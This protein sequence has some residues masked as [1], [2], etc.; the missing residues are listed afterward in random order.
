MDVLHPV[1]CGID[2]H[3]DKLTVC[4]FS[5]P[6]NGKKDRKSISTFSTFPGDLVKLRSFLV[7][8]Q[9]SAVAMEATGIYWKPVYAAL[10]GSCEI[11]VSNAQ[12]IKNVPGRKTDVVDSQWIA[13]LCSL[14]LLA[15]S[16]VPDMPIRELQQLT[17]ERTHLA[18]ERATMVNRLHR[19]LDQQ[20][21]K[22]GSV[23]S[24]LQGTSAKDIL[25]LLA[26]GETDVSKMAECARTTL[27]KRKDELMQALAAPLSDVSRQQLR[28]HLQR[29]DLLDQQCA[30]IDRSLDELCAPYKQA[31][32]RLCEIPGVE[33]L[34]ARKIIAEIGVEMSAFPTPERLASWAG[35]CPGNNESA[36]KKKSGKT[37]AGNKYLKTVLIEAAMAA[38]R[39]RGTYLKTKYYQLKSRRGAKKAAMAI[40]HKILKI[41][42]HLLSNPEAHY[43]ELG[44]GYF[45]ARREEQMKKR[46]VKRLEALGCE[47]RL[48]PKEPK[49]GKEAS[50]TAE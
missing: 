15:K 22:L 9:V 48:L 12:H 38:A 42:W 24:D 19:L 17:R 31:V 14:G 43:R 37:R 6:G 35:V 40:A 18:H 34:T 28:R 30:E 10:E 26:A 44:E 16:F 7:Q 47:V 29:W 49:Q 25:R 23:V 1:C 45:D 27:R 8:N 2:V 32:E 11:I 41:A 36:G 13:Q 5:A 50:P 39:S 21:N 20:G 33:Q 4:V 46:L 3:R